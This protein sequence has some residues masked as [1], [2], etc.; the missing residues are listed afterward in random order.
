MHSVSIKCILVLTA[1][2]SFTCATPARGPIKDLD[3]PYK[4]SWGPQ[5]ISKCNSVQGFDSTW[6]NTPANVER[7]SFDGPN[8]NCVYWT[9]DGT[10]PESG[11]NSKLTWK[12]AQVACSNR[13]GRLAD[14]RSQTENDFVYCLQPM[15]ENRWIGHTLRWQQSP[16]YVEIL[17]RTQA[18]FQPK[19]YGRFICTG[20]PQIPLMKNGLPV[21]NATGGAIYV[22]EN[23]VLRK[24]KR[25]WRSVLKGGNFSDGS[26]WLQPSQQPTEFQGTVFGSPITVFPWT[27]LLGYKTTLPWHFLEPNNRRGT[28]NCVEMGKAWQRQPPTGQWND[29]RCDARKPFVCKKGC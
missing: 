10:T 28:E 7:Q 13:G 14:I 16:D 9:V 1:L 24:G 2:V 27:D 11:D 6:I 17:Q 12:D 22:D 26:Q 29:F 8:K 15:L 20:R 18:C 23:V 25:T 3:N 21:L 5:N 4:S 19:A